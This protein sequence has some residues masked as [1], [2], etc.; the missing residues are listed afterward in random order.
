MIQ[1]K[2]SVVVASENG[3]PL[4]PGVSHDRHFAGLYQR[5]L[6]M[7]NG[8]ARLPQ[9]IGVT[10]CEREAGATT[11]AIR[12]AACAARLGGGPA[13]LVDANLTHPA[14][15]RMFGV[16]AEPGWFEVMSGTMESGQC[17]RATPCEGLSLL[18][19]GCSASG[20]E[21]VY[22][23]AALAELVVLLKHDFA[24]IVFDLPAAAADGAAGVVCSALDGVLVVVRANRTID[25][26]A[27]RA[28]RR[29]E[30]AHASVWGVV[31]NYGA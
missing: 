5:L 23:P 9:A 16:A 12:L 18:T 17:I 20:I 31:L 4:S 24:T 7:R 22:V 25:E 1:S 26:L 27:H 14:I 13:L 3:H 29:L 11:V 6:A 2:S 8:D 10:G 28:K 15:A 19:A 21:P 30:E